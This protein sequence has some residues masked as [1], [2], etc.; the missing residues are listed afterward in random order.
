MRNQRYPYTASLQYTSARFCGS[1][2]IVLE[3]VLT[4]GLCSGALTLGVIQCN[5]VV[6]R[7]DLGNSK[8]GQAVYG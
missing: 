4:A 3:V 2:L 5:A 7:H 6:S 1:A 8:T